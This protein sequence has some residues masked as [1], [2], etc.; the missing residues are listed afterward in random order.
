MYAV[1]YNHARPEIAGFLL[2]EGLD[3]NSQDSDGT[4]ALFLACQ[5]NHHHLMYLLLERENL[6]L[7]L[8]DVHG[9]TALM[10]ATMTQDMEV[11]HCLVAYGADVNKQNHVRYIFLLLCYSPLYIDNCSLVLFAGWEDCADDGDYSAPSGHGQVLPE[12]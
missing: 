3:I 4:C 10:L 2:G 12:R 8:Q 9:N 5:G 11:V 1:Q 7:N 6:D